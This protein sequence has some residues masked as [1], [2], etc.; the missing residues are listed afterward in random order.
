M[1]K[2]QVLE[3]QRTL[4]TTTT[5]ERVLPTLWALADAEEQE[6]YQAARAIFGRLLTRMMDAKAN[7]ETLCWEED[8]PRW[9]E[10]LE[11]LKLHYSAPQA[12][13]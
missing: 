6:D 9:R 2:T 3:T 8:W 1:T 13:A 10:S 11:S 5:N 7:E 4:L 12:S